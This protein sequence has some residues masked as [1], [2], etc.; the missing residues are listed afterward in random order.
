VVKLRRALRAPADPP[1][2]TSAPGRD[3]APSVQHAG[4]VRA[5]ADGGR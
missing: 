1:I 4:A 3:G 2:P 5:R